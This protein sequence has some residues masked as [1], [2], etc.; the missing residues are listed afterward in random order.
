MDSCDRWKTNIDGLI[1]RICDNSE[2]ENGH[3]LRAIN[4][5]ASSTGVDSRFI[6]AVVV[7]PTC[8]FIEQFCFLELTA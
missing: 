3:L 5:V 7:R 6:L 4:A 2:H 8:P 1:S